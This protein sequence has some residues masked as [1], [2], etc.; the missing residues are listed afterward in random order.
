MVSDESGHLVEKHRSVG[1]FKSRTD[2][3]LLHLER[4]DYRVSIRYVICQ[5]T[6]PQYFC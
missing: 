3:N 6:R 2:S 5:I 4:T 1:N